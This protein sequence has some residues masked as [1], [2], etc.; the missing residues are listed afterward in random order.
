MATST[1]K[2]SLAPGL[3]TMDGNP[4]RGSFVSFH[5]HLTRVIYG[6]SKRTLYR[7]H[8]TRQLSQWD[9][10]P[11]PKVIATISG[12]NGD[13]IQTVELVH[14][15][16]ADRF[17]APRA[18][19]L[20]GTPGLAEN[21]GPDPIAWLI[22]GISADQA[23]AL[24]D[25]GCLCSDTLTIFFHKYHPPISG[26][27]GTWQGFTMA[28]ADSEL[29]HRIIVNAVLADPAITRFVHTHRD[30]FPSDAT[31]DK[32]LELFA[33]HIITL[34]INLLSPR[35]PFVAWNVYI[36]YVLICLCRT[37]T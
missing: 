14:T 28:E 34:P 36:N 9:E 27:M 4:S 8:P 12:G 21:N 18:S 13:R 23:Q 25:M 1:A 33:D 26:F 15:N 29:A 30:S 3:T 10:V 6:L 7:N 17:N 35:G 20:I 31:T 19:I 11:Q 22:A 37:R 24:I 16:I 2:A 32:C 5:E